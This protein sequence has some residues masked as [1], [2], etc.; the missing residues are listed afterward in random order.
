VETAAAATGVAVAVA[1]LVV[2]VAAAVLLAIEAHPPSAQRAPSEPF[3]Y[4]TP[5]ETKWSAAGRPPGG[6]NA[7]GSRG[8]TQRPRAKGLR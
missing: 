2:A 1:V 8:Q 5:A 4:L 3:F 6:S 7:R